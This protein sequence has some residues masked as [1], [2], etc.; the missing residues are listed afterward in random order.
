MTESVGK[1][2]LRRGVRPRASVGLVDG[3]DNGLSRYHFG[4]P[5]NQI[6]SLIAAVYQQVPGSFTP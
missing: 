1:S 5:I 3:H 6:N 4:H 2:G